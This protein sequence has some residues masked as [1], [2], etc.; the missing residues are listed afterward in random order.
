[1]TFLNPIWLWGLVGIAVPLAIHLLSRKE[2]SVLRFGSLRHLEES[3]TR[4]FRSVRLNEILLLLL[5]TLMII[6]VVF[7][8]A[9][10][11]FPSLE[12]RS[13][14]KWVLVEN[15]IEDDPA[16]KLMLDSLAGEFEVRVF[17]NGFPTL[18]SSNISSEEQNYWNLLH[19]LG[20]I[21]PDSA[22]I[23]S[24][25]LMS[26]FKSEAVGL[27][28][29]VHWV[30]VE[31]S[32]DSFVH[33]ANETPT[34]SIRLRMGET[35]SGSTSFKT[36]MEPKGR[37]RYTEPVP[38]VTVQMISEPSFKR[39]A[40][41]IVAALAALEDASFVRISV[42][43]GDTT[44]Q[45]PDWRIVL[46]ESPL[47]RKDG[48]KTIGFSACDGNPPLLAPGNTTG[49]AGTY[50]WN[51]TRRL[52]ES[53]VLEAGLLTTLAGIVLPVSTSPAE[54]DYRVLPSEI[55]TSFPGNERNVA[56]KAAAD[57]GIERFIFLLFFLALCTER[58]ISCKRRQ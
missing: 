25:G 22:V 54:I 49:C 37:N 55:V 7:F 45:P 17:A 35:S 28:S 13:E 24:Y 53:V 3:H 52:N 23:F 36:V 44:R 47:I 41:L 1:M 48:V 15:G 42:I 34:D 14:I 31:K 38:V 32:P 58:I 21:G 5:R 51:I 4:Q 29:N 46:M 12:S 43:A 26:G 39:D 19:E 33:R 8:L 6:L 50:E 57:P 27:P 16:I 40:D 18:A 56:A 2:G 9:G 11:G 20:K 10:L 30:T